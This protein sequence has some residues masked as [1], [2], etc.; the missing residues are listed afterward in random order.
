[1]NSG[2]DN[3]TVCIKSIF[4]KWGLYKSIT[5][6]NTNMIKNLP[7]FNDLPL[8]YREIITGFCRSNVVLSTDTKDDVLNQGLWG[9]VNFLNRQ[10]QSLYF[11]N[12]I[13]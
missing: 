6:I 1:M 12:W 2:N 4:D 3:W 13:K 8:F 10:N 5:G 7:S 9:N 11:T